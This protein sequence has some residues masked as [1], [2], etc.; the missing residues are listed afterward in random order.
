MKAEQ[1]GFLI[2]YLDAANNDDRS[3]LAVFVNTDADL[4]TNTPARAM[5]SIHYYTG[6]D[7]WVPKNSV[8]VPVQKGEFYICKIQ[9][10]SG[11]ANNSLY[12][13]PL[14]PA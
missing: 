10:T 1:D 4:L 14:V 8:M 5:T 2:G 9:H 13:I 12:F 7:T 11:K 6:N 3:Q